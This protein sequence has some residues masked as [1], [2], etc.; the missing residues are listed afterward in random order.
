MTEGGRGAR[1][2]AGPWPA[3]TRLTGRA[4]RTALRGLLA[5][6]ELAG[7]GELATG[8]RRVLPGLIPLTY[9][10]DPEIAHRA[11]EAMGVVADRTG[12]GDPETVREAL[13]RLNW[14]I[15]EES[16]GICWRAPE[17]MAEIARRR[18]ERFS[19]YIRIVLS[20]LREMAEEDLAHFRPGVLRAIGRLGGLG[21]EDLEAA[22][23]A[24]V[25]ALSHPDPQTRGMAV[26]ALV[27]VGW[28]G[29]VRDRAELAEDQ[30]PVMVYENGALRRTTV[31]E[32]IAER[33][34]TL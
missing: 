12:D 9:D 27:E 34:K 6:G 8:D 30:G 19:A 2:A 21:G 32:L 17:A 14:L 7:I 3:R 5:D 20:L 25:A 28:A 13:R 22:I 16:G 31:A 11:V 15:T 1:S 26:W 18:P 33:V 23:P 24:V 4:L 10:S 29:A